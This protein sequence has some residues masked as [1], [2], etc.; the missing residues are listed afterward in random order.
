M[1]IHAPGTLPP[2][3]DNLSIPQFFLDSQHSTRPVRNVDAPWLIEDQ[4]GR[5]IGFEEVSKLE[6]GIR[7]SP[8]R[9][10]YIASGSYIWSGKCLKH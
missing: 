3:P 10:A 6:H 5:K 8:N 7:G 9:K 4:S 2:I 1:D